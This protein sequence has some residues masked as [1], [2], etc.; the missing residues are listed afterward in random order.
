MGEMGKAMMGTGEA[1]GENRAQE[2]AE[3]AIANPLLD[4]ISLRGA[5][6]VL[7]NI[8]GGDPDG[9]Y[10]WWY[11]GTTDDEGEFTANTVNFGGWVDDEVDRLLDEGRSELDPATRVEIY[12]DLN[13]RMATQVHGIW[14][15]HTPWAIVT[16]PDVHGILGPPL[17]DGSEPSPQINDGHR[18]VGMWIAA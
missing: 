17:P 6:G 18:T 10:V 14:L 12:Q 11:S 4:E 9:T 15:W 7:I 1:S 5:K 3:R 2:A 8:T 13:W 16:A